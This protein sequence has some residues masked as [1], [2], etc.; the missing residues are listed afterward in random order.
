[1]NA[2]RTFLAAIGLSM[3]AA[4]GGGADGGADGSAT[5][6]VISGSVTKGPVHNATVTAYVIEGGQK[7]AQL[8]TARTDADGNFTLSIGGHAGP[9][10]LQASG[11][12]YTDEATGTAMTMA[13]GD[14]LT[15]ALPGFAAGAAHHGAQVT[16]LTAMAQ[17]MAHRMDG[18]MT[19]A[20]IT[21]ANAALG[22]YFSVADILHVRPMNPLVA[23]ASASAGDDARNY[24][25]TLAAMSRY[26][27]S[28][29]MATSSSMVTA[30][31]NDAG[32]GVMDGKRAADPIPMPMHGM[33]GGGMMAATAGTSGLA[34]AMTDF[35][36]SAANASGATA[37]HME[38]LIHKLTH[39]D[40]HF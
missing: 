6:G 8:A 9:V 16:P 38:T 13:P 28:L 36:N 39:S 31:M 30:M 22:H 40:G 32:D 24:G 14:V 18:G 3:L 12:G 7:G 5:S 4:C 27:L 17:A 33:M 2:V 26:A 29:N 35:M 25:M 11:G 20:N 15:A 37:A 10:M 19:D 23:G 34:A 1:M 21:T